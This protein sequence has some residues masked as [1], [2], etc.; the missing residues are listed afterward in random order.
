[1]IRLFVLCA[2]AFAGAAPVAAAT[3]ALDPSHTSVQFAIRHM[4]V[5]NVRGEFTKLSGT[6]QGDESAPAEAVI[7]VT[8]DAASIDTRDAKRDDHLRGKDFFDVATHPTITFKSKKIAPAG[9]AAFKVTGDLTMHGVTKEV[10]LDVADVTPAIKDPFGKTRA[11]ARATTK[12]NRK[13]FGI[14]WSKTMDTGG[15]VVG[16]EVTVTIDVEAIKQ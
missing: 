16:D 10:V 4:M 9:A 5:S 3:W 8:I 7:D 11:G 6:V 1:M 15:L 2:A 13:D 12:V 14:D